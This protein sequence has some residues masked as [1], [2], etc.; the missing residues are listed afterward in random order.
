[1][2]LPNFKIEENQKINDMLNDY[3]EDK[4][5]KEIIVKVDE[6]DVVEMYETPFDG[7]NEVKYIKEIEKIIRNS[8]EYKN[9]VQ[10]LRTEFDLNQCRFYDNID[11]SELK[12]SIELHHYPASLFDIVAAV[13]ESLK[14]SNMINAYKTFDVAN[15]VMKL[16]Y[17]GII[18]LVPL[19]KTNHDLTHNG[20]LFIPLNDKY[21]FGDY[22]KLF[23][24]ERL[25]FDNLFFEKLNVIKKKTSEYEITGENLTESLFENKEIKIEMKEAISPMKIN[26]EESET[27]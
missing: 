10:M 15:L 2:K 8:F 19:T 17:E 4:K 14:E 5:S 7:F 23:N 18:G 11:I 1:M 9:Y 6:T 26:K 25:V 16:H 21:V 27:A 12:I 20:E 24:D 3:N 13:R 22:E